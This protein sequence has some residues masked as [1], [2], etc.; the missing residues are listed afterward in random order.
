MTKTIFP[1]FIRYKHILYIKCPTRATRAISTHSRP[2]IN[3]ITRLCVTFLH[4]DLL[5][6]CRRENI[7]CGYNG[8]SD[9]FQRV[10]PRDLRALIIAGLLSK[11][12]L[13]FFFLSL[14]VFY[15]TLLLEKELEA[16]EKQNEHE[17]MGK[18]I[19]KILA[20]EILN[21][22]DQKMTRRSVQS[23]RNDPRKPKKRR[24][25]KQKT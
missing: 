25:A 10:F 2:T 24:E 19:G 12:K 3:F 4:D 23:N 22:S 1:I 11:L 20:N 17:W 7:T 14:K 21:Q 18:R 16:T 9:I 13:S 8:I 6:R 5:F 15:S